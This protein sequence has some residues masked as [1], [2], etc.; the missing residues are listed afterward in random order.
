MYSIGTVEWHGFDTN[1]YLGVFILDPAYESRFEVQSAYFYNRTQGVF[2]Q[3]RGGSWTIIVLQNIVL[4]PNVSTPEEAAAYLIN[5]GIGFFYNFDTNGQRYIYFAITGLQWIVSFTREPVP[6]TD[7]YAGMSGSVSITS[8][9]AFI[10]NPAERK[11]YD[12]NAPTRFSYV[13][14][15]NQYSGIF[16]T[17]NG[18]ARVSYTVRGS[19]VPEDTDPFPILSGNLIGYFNFRDS[20]GNW[21]FPD[22]RKVDITTFSLTVPEGPD[23]ITGDPIVVSGNNIPSRVTYRDSR[24]RGIGLAYGIEGFFQDMARQGFLFP[25]VGPYE[26][27]IPINQLAPR[28]NAYVS[29]PAGAVEM[30]LRAIGQQNISWNMPVSAY[31]VNVAF[32]DDVFGISQVNSIVNPPPPEPIVPGCLLRPR[33]A[34]FIIQ[35]LP[36]RTLFDL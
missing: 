16:G 5:N 15:R 2:K 12:G 3:A 24:G 8:G 7:K 34:P 11:S 10:G 29:I 27:S 20:N 4:I 18:Y 21:I 13:S 17:N 22:G 28:T 6:N 32:F 35:D 19:N 30:R 26:A 31:S 14:L 1:L 33:L 25:A 36:T 9:L 23:W